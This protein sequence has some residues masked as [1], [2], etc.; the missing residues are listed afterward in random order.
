MIVA[1]KSGAPTHP[2]WY[3]NVVAKP[4]VTV[5]VG[6]D[7]FE[8][9]A[10]VARGAE[11]DRLYAAHALVFP[12]FNVYRQMTSRVIPVVLLERIARTRLPKRA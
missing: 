3:L 11:H 8:A 7:T 12:V 9:R 5:E 2:A 6:G 10:R 1:S 4:V